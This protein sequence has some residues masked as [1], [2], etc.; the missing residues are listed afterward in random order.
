MT[1]SAITI[2]GKDK[3][4]MLLRYAPKAMTR[5]I[6]SWLRAEQAAFVGKRGSFTKEIQTKKRK[7][8][9]GNWGRYVSRSFIGHVYDSS[10]LNKMRLH[11]G[12]DDAK[13]KKMPFIEALGK[14]GTITPKNAAWLIIPFYKNLL[15]AGLFGRRGAAGKNSWGK[16]LGELSRAGQIQM[17]RKGGRLFV[18]GDAPDKGGSHKTRHM[19]TLD[20]KLLFVGVR[21]SRVPQQFDFQG[22]WASRQAGLTERGD[23]RIARTIRALERGYMRFA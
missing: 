17:I 7:Y 2:L 3:I 1:D 20:R 6:Y 15:S 5:T 13:L 12:Y 8:R 18:F 11:M 14:G 21:R 10:D 9:P 4:D 22:A 16:L 23:V 19:H